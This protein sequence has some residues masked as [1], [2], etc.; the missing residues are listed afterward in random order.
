[1]SKL[2][3]LITATATGDVAASR[4]LKPNYINVD[5]EH[6]YDPHSYDVLYDIGM[7]LHKKTRIARSLSEQINA[8]A[9][10]DMLTNVRRAMI[11]E[12]FGEFRHYLVEMRA[13]LYDND[14]YRIKT[15]LAEMEH[16]MFHE[17][18]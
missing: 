11:E 14:D 17:G 4:K 16:Q 8:E 10:Q 3:H 9:E 13:A 5:V 12:V 1:M 2:A 7:R 15:L 6:S 18:I